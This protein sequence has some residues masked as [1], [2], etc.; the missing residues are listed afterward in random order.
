[1]TLPPELT[2]EFPVVAIVL[3]V[4]GAVGVGGFAFVKWLVSW[5]SKEAAIWRQFMADQ[6]AQRAAQNDK[7]DKIQ[8]GMIAA[9]QG[10]ISRFDKLESRIET[11]HKLVEQIAERRKTGGL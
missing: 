4:F 9:L 2:A 1:M 5:Q 7:R 8:D 11:H 10:M 6:E 3:I